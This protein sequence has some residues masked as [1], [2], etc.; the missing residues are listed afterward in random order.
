MLLHA[1]KDRDSNAKLVGVERD[2]T[3]LQQ[4]KDTAPRGTKLILADY[5]FAEAGQFEGIIANPPYV[6]SQR[7]EYSEANWRY[8]DERFGI[9][10]DRLTNLYALFLLKIWED[11]APG[12]RAAVLIPAEFLNANFGEEIKDRL[13]KDLKPAGVVVFAPELNLFSDALTTSAI[14]FLDRGR[15]KDAAIKAIKANTLSDAEM[16]VDDLLGKSGNS[17]M[18]KV[19]DLRKFDPGQKWLNVLLEDAPS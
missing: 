3:T 2:S 18:L 14:I 10:L 12:G 16:L 11:L 7:L 6:K 15:A 4:A 1:C 13:L 5:L 19:H 9:P 8:F 17:S